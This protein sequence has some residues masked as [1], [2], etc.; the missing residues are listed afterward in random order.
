MNKKI[1]PK[2]NN[3]KEE[4]EFWDAHSVTDYLK[5]STPVKFSYNPSNEKKETLTLRVAPSLKNEIEK[6]AKSYDISS[7]SLV[8]MWVV[9]KLKDSKAF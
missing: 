2:F 8:R 7:S 1:V 9:E 4:A 3:Y 5:E 6:R